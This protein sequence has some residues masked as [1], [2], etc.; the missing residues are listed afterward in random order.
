MRYRPLFLVCITAI[1]ACGSHPPP[2]PMPDGLTRSPVNTLE[3][4]IAY[5]ARNAAPP[6]SVPPQ[7]GAA[8]A[9]ERFEAPVGRARA[10]SAYEDHVDEDAP[11]IDKLRHA[12]ISFE[13]NELLEIRP[14]SMVFNIPCTPGS[15]DCRPSQALERVLL[16][17]AARSPRVEIRGRTDATSASASDQVI[18]ERRAQQA[19]RLLAS[20]AIS[21]TVIH[22]SALATGGHIADNS[23]PQGRASNRRVEIE[24]MD[25]SPATNNDIESGDPHERDRT[26]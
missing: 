12:S 16:H 13:S 10:K 15:V 5:T 26:E 19:Q 23:T 22:L 1:T 2:A 20:N 7:R 24:V 8:A 25:I 11:H 17:A 6:T 21:E 18:A 9:I 3:R 4:I 14:R